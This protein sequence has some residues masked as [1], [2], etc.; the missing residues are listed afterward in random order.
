MIMGKCSYHMFVFH[1]F[2][3]SYRSSGTGRLI[4]FSLDSM[5]MHSIVLK[6]SSDVLP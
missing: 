5:D 4:H 3:S 2:L 1:L 6:S